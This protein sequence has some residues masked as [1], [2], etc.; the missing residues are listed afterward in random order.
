M[1][2]FPNFCSTFCFICVN[3]LFSNTKTAVEPNQSDALEKSEY[4]L[5]L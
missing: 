1:A 2:F 4:T 3:L 5:F